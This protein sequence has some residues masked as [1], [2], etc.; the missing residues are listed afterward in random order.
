MSEKNPPS[1][2]GLYLAKDNENYT[3]WNLV[4][5]IYGVKPYLKWHI[6]NYTENSTVYVHVNDLY[7]GPRI[8]VLQE[9]TVEGLQS[10]DNHAK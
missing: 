6:W 1:E 10:L 4:V 8:A 2:A 5:I 7:F 9:G 3:W